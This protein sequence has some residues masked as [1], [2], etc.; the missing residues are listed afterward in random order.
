MFLLCVVA[1]WSQAQ[2]SGSASTYEWLKGSKISDKLRKGI[3]Y[4]RDFHEGRRDLA[5][6]ED[7]LNSIGYNSLDAVAHDNRVTII[8]IGS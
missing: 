3:E 8:T 5:Q 6:T 1:Q 2:I 7:S 4:L